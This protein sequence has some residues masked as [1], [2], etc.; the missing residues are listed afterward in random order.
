MFKKLFFVFILSLFF[1][2]TALAVDAFDVIDLGIGALT[3]SMPLLLSL[4]ILVFFWGIVKFINHAGDEKAVEEGKQLMIW[5]L[6]GLFVIVGIWGIVGY[7]QSTLGLDEFTG[8][9]SIITIPT[10]VP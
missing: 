7:I 8:G 5:G 9:G 10:T 1:P 4:A 3:T 6:I 2:A